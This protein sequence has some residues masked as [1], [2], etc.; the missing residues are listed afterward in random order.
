MLKLKGGTCSTDVCVLHDAYHPFLRFFALTFVRGY[1]TVC[2]GLVSR[3]R[4]TRE[5]SPFAE[6][7]DSLPSQSHMVG[8]LGQAVDQFALSDAH[9]NMFP[10]HILSQLVMCS[11]D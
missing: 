1:K 2:N 4:G 10:I 3:S 11:Y 8:Q 5:C 6:T 9:L 7:D